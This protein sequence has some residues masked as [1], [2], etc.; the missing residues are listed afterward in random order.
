MSQGMTLPQE[1]N[2][3]TVPWYKL[4]VVC[5][6]VGIAPFLERTALLLRMKCLLLDIKMFSCKSL[7]LSFLGSVI[8]L[9]VHAGMTNVLFLPVPAIASATG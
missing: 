3:R 2:S 1:S 8:T 4:C 9:H 5:W 6:H 7:N